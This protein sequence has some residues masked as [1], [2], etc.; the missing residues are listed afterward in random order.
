MEEVSSESS[1]KM[2]PRLKL[3]GLL[4][5]ESKKRMVGG[6]NQKGKRRPP[7]V[8][9]LWK[10]GGRRPCEPLMVRATT[11]GHKG[12]VLEEKEKRQV[13]RVRRLEA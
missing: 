13:K 2:R 4:L 5:Q 1:R 6:W 10:R 8:T 7:E 11:S 12:K 3:R 9:V